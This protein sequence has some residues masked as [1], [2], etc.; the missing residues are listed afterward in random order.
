MKSKLGV[1]VKRPLADFLPSIAI[2]AKDLAIDITNHNI[3]HKNL[4]GEPPITDEHIQNNKEVRDL[5]IKRGIYIENVSKADDIKKVERKIKS[6]EKKLIDKEFKKLE[7]Q[8]TF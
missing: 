2:T 8:W 5:L 3:E 6:S 4:Y 7:N 1:P